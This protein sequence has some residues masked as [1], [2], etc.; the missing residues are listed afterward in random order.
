MRSVWLSRRLKSR[1]EC[2]SFDAITR[3][4]AVL[5]KEGVGTIRLFRRE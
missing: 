1:F 4:K 3:P 5:P 2:R